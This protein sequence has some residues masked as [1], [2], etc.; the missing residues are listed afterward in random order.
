MNFRI[1]CISLRSKRLYEKQKRRIITDFYLIERN[2]ELFS[3][4]IVSFFRFFFGE[5]HFFDHLVENLLLFY[6]IFFRVD[7]LFACIFAEFVREL[8]RKAVLHSFLSESDVNV[9]ICYGDVKFVSK[10]V[11]DDV[12]LDCKFCIV[13]DLCKFFCRNFFSLELAFVVV[14]SCIFLVQHE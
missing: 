4:L 2:I 9:F 5:N 8:S 11:E 3:F 6:L 1:G 10:S 7:S 14:D 12:S 13:F